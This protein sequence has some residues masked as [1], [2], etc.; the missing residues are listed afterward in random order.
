[1]LEV[2][3]TVEAV[4]YKKRIVTLRGAK[5][6]TITLRADK[7]V[8]NFDQLKKGDVVLTDYVESIAIYMRAAGAPPSAAETRL[9]SVAPKG[10]KVGVLLAETFQLLAVIEAIDA[11]ARQVTLKEPDGSRLLVPVDKSFRNLERFRKGEEVALRITEA[12]A[13]K[14]EKSK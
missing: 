5:G 12:I 3:A 2:K 13:I 7:A 11:K 6:S 14:V 9:V 10:A 4:D 1:V 8:R